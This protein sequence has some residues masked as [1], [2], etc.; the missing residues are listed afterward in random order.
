M[1]KSHKTID[2]L[3]E[4]L[5]LWI[6]DRSAIVS[7]KDKW[8]EQT[9]ENIF[10]VPPQKSLSEEKSAEMLERLREKIRQLETFGDLLSFRIQQKAFDLTAL[11]NE[12]KL[13]QDILEQLS[14]DNLFPSRVPVLLMKRLIEFLEIP[15]DKAKSSLQRTAM[16]IIENQTVQN[17]SAITPI[18]ARRL[19][20]DKIDKVRTIA[21]GTGSIDPHVA[22][23]SLEIYLR[24]LEVLFATENSFQG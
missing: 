7:V 16:L 10:D 15:L 19:S 2:A 18:F 17:A 20:I 8:I 22:Q 6:L 3:D 4:L 13:S 1:T 12:V 11:A 9:V 14:R 23:T 24:R 5:R 21:V